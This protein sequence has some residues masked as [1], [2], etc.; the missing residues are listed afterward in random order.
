MMSTPCQT[1]IV[2]G[3]MFFFHAFDVG[4]EIDLEAVTRERLVT[5]LPHALATYFKNY[6]IPLSVE[7]P[8]GVQS[9]DYPCESAKLHNFGAITLRYR[10]PFTSTLE[11]LRST[12]I[13]LDALYEDESV[14]AAG[15]LFNR[16]RG[17]T[18]QPR[19]FQVRNSYTLIQVAQL[20][21]GATDLSTL[22]RDY[23]HLFASLL[24]FET[25]KL[26]EHLKDEILASAFSYY[27]KDLIIIDTQ[28]ALIC[29]D[30]YA[31]VLDIFE[32]ANVQHLELQYFDRLLDKQ[33]HIAYEQERKSPPMTAY[34]PFIGVLVSDPVGDLS[35]LK[36]D[37]S[38][39]TDR[40][41]T[42]I[43]LAG[44]AY[45]S[46]LYQMLSRKLDLDNWKGSI[47]R[48][49]DIIHDIGSIYQHK[50]EVIR[51]DILTCSIIILIMLELII[52]T[53]KLS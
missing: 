36:V 38:V 48:K 23:G 12:L 45:I 22:T 39:I 50:L 15:A 13:A 20:P 2:T 1:P 44:E 43:K 18:K 27:Q 17:H 28:A 42:S 25:E 5:I 31:E 29:D 21:A 26:S 47:A 41:E 32:F 46:Q 10:V 53:L 24:R 3:N 7:L 16:I 9:R 49:L 37:I 6:H 40:L 33:L 11:E 35:K 30:E 4:D 8:V 51:E 52:G 34:L 19:F 14:K